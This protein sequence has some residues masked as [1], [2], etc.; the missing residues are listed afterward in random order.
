MGAAPPSPCFCL[1][2]YQRDFSLGFTPQA[3]TFVYDSD[4]ITI[5]NGKGIV[6]S[7]FAE[8]VEVLSHECREFIPIEREIGEHLLNSG[9]ELGKGGVVRIPHDLLAQKLPEAFDQVQVWRVG[10]Q[11]QQANA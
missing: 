11:K 7:C 3:P 8:E 4:S 6:L 1:R 2:L 5:L 10:R 9:L